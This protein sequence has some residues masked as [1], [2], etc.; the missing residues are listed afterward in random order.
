MPRPTWSQEYLAYRAADDWWLLCV[1]T[2]WP[3]LEGMLAAM[4]NGDALTHPDCREAAEHRAQALS[5][6]TKTFLGPKPELEITS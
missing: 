5:D 3:S 2:A 6:W 1:R 4:S